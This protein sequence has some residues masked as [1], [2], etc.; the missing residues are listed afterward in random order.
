MK[1][2]FLFI[3]VLGMLSLGASKV[4]MAQDEEAT[5]TLTEAVTDTLAVDS[6]E[7]TIDEEVVADEPEEGSVLHKA[8]KRKF[9]A[10][11]TIFIC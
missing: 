6:A 10:W 5:D 1:K 7:V 3:A 11:K 8:I 9:I 2:L 4:V